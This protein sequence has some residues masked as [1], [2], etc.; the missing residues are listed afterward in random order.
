MIDDNLF[1][2]IHGGDTSAKRRKVMFDSSSTL[3]LYTDLTLFDGAAAG[4]AAGEG[5][6]DGA[7]GTAEQTAPGN[8]RRAKTKGGDFENIIYGKQESMPK[9]EP[10]VTVTSDTQEDRRRAYDELIR[11]EYK[12]IYTEDTQRIINRRFKETKELQEKVDK[13]QGI[14][15]VLGSRYGVDSTDT[16]GL[17]AA[18]ENDDAYW[19][20]AAEE[21]GMTVAQYKQFQKL[22]RENSELMAAQK[23]GMD[24]L[25]AQQQAQA[26]YNEATE[27]KKKF[28]KFNLS[29]ELKDPAFMSMLKS[30]TPME[31]AYKVQHFDEL[32]GDTM[33]VTAKAV[34]R[35]VV[36]N[37]RAKGRRAPENGTAGQ[38]AFTIKDDVSKLTR[39]DRA[40][41]ARRAARGETIRF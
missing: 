29:N 4:T 13:Y 38:S 20:E 14:M 33:H 31:H 3:L 35:N 8:T 24:K 6:G 37:I 26:W 1:I 12:D 25:R 5:A 11:G 22:Q 18:L 16:A 28:P 9:A 27:L 23:A 40:E 32:M 30:G 7:L 39:K 15:N 19:S 36:D 2:T 10:D 41:I 17:M 21:A 34:E